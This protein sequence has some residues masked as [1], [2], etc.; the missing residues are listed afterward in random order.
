MDEPESVGGKNTTAAPLKYLLG[1]LA[2][3]TVITMKMY[4]NRKQWDVG[5]IDINVELKEF[6]STDGTKN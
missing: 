1:A 5:N 4:A 6:L 2:S 3:C